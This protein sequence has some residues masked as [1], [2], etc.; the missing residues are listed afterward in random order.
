MIP[1]L[2]FAFRQLAKAP[3]FTLVAVLTLAL[4]IGAN[5]AIFSV[6]NGVLLAP[7]PYPDSGR[8][9]QLGEAPQPGSYIPFASGGAFMDWQDRSTQLQ[10]IAAA[11][12]EDENLTGVSE[13]VRIPGLEVSSGYLRVLGIAPAM[14]RDFLPSEDSAGGNN[15]VVIISHDLWKS[16]L[17]SDPAIV[18]K[19]IHLDGLS[20]TVIGVLAPNALFQSDAG[21][22]VPSLIRATPH[23][24]SRDYDYVVQVVGRLKPGATAARAAEELTVAK[25]ATR[26]LYPVFKQKWTVGILSLHEAIFGNIRPYVLTLLGAV[27]VVLLI[28]CAN[29]ANLLLARATVRQSEI[30]VR[31]ALGATRGRIVRQLLTESLLLAGMGGVSG[32]VLAVASIRPLV[33]FSAIREV[34]GSTIGL[35]PL[36]LLFTL[37]ASMATG[38]VFGL[39]PAL[40]AT[41]PNLSDQLKE[42]LRGSTA[43]ARRRAQTLL[44]VSE[45]ALT[46]VLLVSAGLLLRS[47]VNAMNSRMGFNTENV[48]VFDLSIPNAKAP[49]TAD[50]V[51]LQQ[52]ILERLAQLPGVSRVGMASAAPMNGGNNLGDLISREDRPDTRNDYS[53]GFDSVGGDFFQTLQIPLLR[54][55]FLTREDDTETA[56][57]VMVV[58]DILAGSLFGKTDPIGKQL[59]F[60]G[61]VWEIVGVVRSVR[62][63]Q[64]D[65]NDPPAVYFGRTYFPWWTCIVVRTSVPPLTLA[66]E[67]RGAVREIDPDLPIARFNTLQ[68]SVES[69]LQVRRVVLV[70][71][72]IFAVT[73]L[74]LACVG[75]YGVISY[76]VAQRTREVGIRMALGA[77]SGQVVLMILRQGI[78]FVAIG[79][80]VGVAASIGAGKLLAQQL[81]EVSSADPLVIATVALALLAVAVLASWLPARRAA[82]VNPSIALRAE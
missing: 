51:R 53:A 12:S 34:S 63:Y 80:L 71:L 22:L 18:G 46:V 37:G 79:L 62:R 59:H 21:F 19:Q 27:S 45:T 28:A 49:E 25:S 52:R 43:G 72:G 65:G 39:I 15:A 55:R 32:L 17:G 23:R 50:K 61:A 40:S 3:A 7:L 58:N 48:L 47:F 5:T 14:G 31:V 9:V 13:P 54:G 70:L 68:S 30:S 33:A 69:T 64:L 74:V 41:R 35:S 77:G 67:I 11:H 66:S 24:Q 56:P 57:K 76:S 4:G 82:R 75:I 1:D 73:A 29:V 20:L 60:K 16:H 6:V 36:V 44:L 26:S 38:L 8:L 2:K 10:S 78:K 81:Y 42:G